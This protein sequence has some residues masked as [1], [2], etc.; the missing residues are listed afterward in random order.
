VEHRAIVRVWDDKQS[1]QLDTV[2]K[3]LAI[4]GERVNR[5]ISPGFKPNP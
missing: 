2:K 3:Q 1:A 4:V 5:Q